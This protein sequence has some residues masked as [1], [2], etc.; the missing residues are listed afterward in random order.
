M[1]L[2]EEKNFPN[3]INCTIYFP[4]KIAVS[5]TFE[6]SLYLL[7]NGK[8]HFGGFMLEKML[9]TFD[10]NSEVTEVNGKTWTLDHVAAFL[11]RSSCLPE[12]EESL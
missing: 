11:R 7:N 5:L 2:E 1:K 10:H 8:I 12:L 3:I 6:N 9:N 4:V